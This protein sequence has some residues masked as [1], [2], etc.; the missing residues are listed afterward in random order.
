MKQ[1]FNR[2]NLC[3]QQQSI[4]RHEFRVYNRQNSLDDIDKK[5]MVCDLINCH[6]NT[7]F[8]A[9]GERDATDVGPNS[10][11]QAAK[12]AGGGMDLYCC[13]CICIG[14]STCWLRCELWY[15]LFCYSF[16]STTSVCLLYTSLSY[17]CT[18]LTVYAFTSNLIYFCLRLRS[19]RNRTHIMNQFSRW[20]PTQTA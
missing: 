12:E 19:S 8:E 11:R 9:A 18:I 1:P 14:G 20:L 5:L 7:S 15:V 16:L 2:A 17:A 13:I 10:Q 3:H 6:K 4:A